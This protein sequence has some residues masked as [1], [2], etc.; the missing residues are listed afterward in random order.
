MSPRIR[1]ASCSIVSG[2]EVSSRAGKEPLSPGAET[3]MG[4]EES[5]GGGG[6]SEDFHPE[7]PPKVYLNLNHKFP[8]V[9]FSVFFSWE[10]ERSGEAE[11]C[12]RFGV[13]GLGRFCLMKENGEGE[14]LEEK[15]LF[16]RDYFSVP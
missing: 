8:P 14:K 4:R 13:R 2:L 12:E 6:K 10:R 9:L 3:L 15:F 7:P 1:E 16:E 5:F 11:L